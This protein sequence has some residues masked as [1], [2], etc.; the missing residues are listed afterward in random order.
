MKTR[1]GFSQRTFGIAWLGQ[2]LAVAAWLLVVGSSPAV[3]AQDAGDDQNAE[4]AVAA[5]ADPVN[6]P[7]PAQTTGS[8]TPVEPPSYL[9]W[10]FEAL[11]WL[12]SIIFLFLSFTL[13]ALMVMNSLAAR[14]ENVCPLHLVEAF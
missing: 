3:F 13:V 7:A 10:T 5:P 8:T 2:F 1:N 12:Y 6:A 4:A 11:G 14:R 9:E